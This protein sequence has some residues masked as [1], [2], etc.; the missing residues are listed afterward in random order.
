[1][2]KRTDYHR[3][4]DQKHRAK[5]SKRRLE[6][7]YKVRVGENKPDTSRQVVEAF[8]I[9]TIPLNELLKRTQLQGLRGPQGQRRQE[10][11]DSPWLFAINFKKRTKTHLNI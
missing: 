9:P 7:Y 3:E 4:Y 10:A 11:N 6:N 2:K 5:L 8:Q 1:M